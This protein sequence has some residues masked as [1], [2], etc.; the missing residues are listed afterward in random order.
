MSI[1]HRRQLL[2]FFIVAFA[3]V[4]LIGNGLGNQVLREGVDGGSGR[5]AAVAS[6]VTLMPGQTAVELGGSARGTTVVRS[7]SAPAP[8]GTT[9]GRVATHRTEPVR[10]GPRRSEQAP[11]DREVPRKSK[12]FGQKD[13]GKRATPGSARTSTARTVADTDTTVHGKKAHAKKH[14]EHARTTRR[15]DR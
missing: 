1:E 4:L 11:S 15:H 2:A 13:T 10:V 5:Q 14:G 9:S 3:A 12:A 6:G 7:D 8:S